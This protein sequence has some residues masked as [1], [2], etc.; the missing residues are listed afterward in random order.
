MDT[1]QFLIELQAKLDEAASK[2]LINS[3]IASLQDKL[4]KLKLQATLDPNAAQKLANDIG[5]LINQK[6]TISNI[7]VDSG[8]AVKEA[9]KTGRQIGDA[10]NKGISSSIKDIKNEISN[11]VKSI[12]RLNAANIIKEM[13]LNR[14]SVETDVVD[15]VRL[16]TTE[17]NKLGREAAKT[18]SDSSWE[19]LITK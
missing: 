2:G 10:V 13:N 19:Q 17:I 18:N 1:N 9:Q 16:L 3:D 8:Q 4:D 14:G 11:T 6:I 12:P 5:K 7:N 15:K